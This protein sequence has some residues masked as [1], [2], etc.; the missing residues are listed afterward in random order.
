MKSIRWFP[1][2]LMTFCLLSEAKKDGGM[3]M[4]GFGFLHPDNNGFANS[5]QGSSTALQF[6]NSGYVALGNG[7]TAEIYYDRSDDAGST[8]YTSLTPSFTWANGTVGMGVYAKRAG[9]SFE[10]AK[11]TD[12]VGG[13]L[14][15]GLWKGRV[16]AGVGY[17]RSI[18]NKQSSDGILTGSFALNGNKGIGP[19]IGA[20]AYTTVNAAK[21]TV[22]AIGAIG[23]G[24]K[25][26]CNVEG[27]F[28]L[29]NIDKTQSWV[30]STAL[31]IGTRVVYIGGA[32]Y[33]N[34][35]QSSFSHN[36]AARLGV[37]IA[38]WL[39]ASVHGLHT[40]KDGN[41]PVWGGTVRANF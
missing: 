3:A 18:D 41:D 11:S 24:F 25:H 20:G 5:H 26:N 4:G 16:S 17:M 28:E 14:G 29:P 33:Y 31:T 13:I 27:S 32:Y 30:G 1:I 38:H 8:N 19:A 6:A 36:G 40:F 23:Y 10:A 15:L 35:T 39:D 12:S 34:K 9:T 22:G 7:S 21:N 37:R 2:F